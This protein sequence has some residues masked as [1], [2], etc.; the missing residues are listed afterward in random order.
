MLDAIDSKRCEGI[1]CGDM[2]HIPEG[3]ARAM[4]LLDGNYGP[5]L[6]AQH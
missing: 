1:F 5:C 6:L 3:Q 2:Q 4:E